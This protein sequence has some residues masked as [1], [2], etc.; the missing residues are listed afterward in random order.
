MDHGRFAQFVSGKVDVTKATDF[1]IV[2][3]RDNLPFGDAGGLPISGLAPRS[4]R[5]ETER[6]AD[7]S[8]IR[9]WCV[10][11]EDCGPSYLAAAGMSLA[12]PRESGRFGQSFEAGFKVCTAPESHCWPDRTRWPGAGGGGPRC[13]LP[14]AGGSATL[15]A[16]PSQGEAM[17]QTTLPPP[18]SHAGLAIISSS[19]VVSL[20]DSGAAFREVAEHN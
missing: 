4:C 20:P 9:P 6:L 10:A 12:V 3:Y 2:F 18:P 11:P 8:V 13:G 16:R 14:G 1:V 17:T 5:F 19:F 7:H 15:C